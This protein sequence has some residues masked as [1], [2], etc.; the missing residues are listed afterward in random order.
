MC[1]V[2]QYLFNNSYLC[3]DVTVSKSKKLPT[4]GA[5]HCPWEDAMR[6]SQMRWAGASH[7]GILGQGSRLGPV[8]AVGA[9]AGISTGGIQ[10]RKWVTRCWRADQSQGNLEWC[11]IVT[12]K[13]Q[14]C[15]DRGA[16]RHGGDYQHLEVQKNGCCPVGIGTLGACRR[17]HLL[18]HLGLLK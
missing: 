11:S 8:T 10:S 17:D 5:S 4:Q 1:P 12:A 7:G 18:A 14:S 2:L 16:R 15:Q 9:T 6:V 13:P 3:W